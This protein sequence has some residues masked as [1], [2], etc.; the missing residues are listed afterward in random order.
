MMD[1]ILLEIHKIKE[2]NGNRYATME[3]LARGLV[4]RERATLAQGRAVV[5]NPLRQNVKIRVR[6]TKRYLKA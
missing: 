4:E 6:V 3:S 1:P 2:A 5:S